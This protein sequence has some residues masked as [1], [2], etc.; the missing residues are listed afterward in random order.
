GRRSFAFVARWVG[1]EQ[2]RRVG[3]L[4]L[5]GVG[6]LH[7]PRRVYP[8]RTLA[9]QV[10]GFA[11]IDGRGV[12]GIEQIEDAWLRGT[13]RRIPVERD[14]RGRLLSAG[15]EERWSTAGG[16]IALTIDSALQADAEAALAETV[17][18]TGARGGVV[19]S[20]DPRSG[21]IL[22][23]AEAP[24]FDPNRFREIDYRSTRSRAFLDASDPGSTMK[25][26]LLA[27]ALEHG[28]VTP[29]QEFDCEGGSYQVPGRVIHDSRPHGVLTVAE[30]LQ[31]S[32]NIC[33]AKI[34]FALGRRPH[35]DAL[36]RFGFGEVTGIGFPGES[37]GVLRPWSEWRPLDHATIAFGQGVS[38]TP[39]QMAA[40]T[41]ALANG[42]QWLRPRLVKARRA[43]RGP[44]R[45][46]RT[47]TPH[48][49]TSPA[50]AALVVAM[51]ERVVSAEGTARRAALSGV[52]VAG[53]T[54]TAQKFDP[55]TGTYADDR[56]A[57]WFIGIVPADDPKLVIVTGVDEPARPLHTGGA[58]AAPLFARVASAQ[59]ARFGILA[60]PVFDAPAAPGLPATRLA[61]AV[62]NAAPATPAVS[63]S[64]LG[65][66]PVAA[67]PFAEPAE[68]TAPPVQLM[69][70]GD[71][72][73]LPD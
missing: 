39:I 44:W 56:F 42:G 11:N 18:R 69:R 40:A 21:E 12:R 29:D 64:P 43:A 35:F 24:G 72:M 58:A 3:A 19:I 23:L 2:A 17:L 34:A 13:A 15:G 63:S 70:F 73:L 16:D 55:E 59:L 36:R 25:A 28:A 60:E 67:R 53:K 27:G 8:N 22:A 45:P 65:A 38:V 57:A 66:A 48:R 68:A 14:A 47:N 4:S 52:R 7:E 37:A 26:F 6:V 61:A 5:D 54:G 10:L 71:R 20:L 49:A 9:A 62:K 46:A 41:A 32:S 50:A 30:V 1:K 31:V 51:M 33:A